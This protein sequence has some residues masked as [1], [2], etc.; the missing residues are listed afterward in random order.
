VLTETGG[1][2]LA[3]DGEIRIYEQSP[4]LPRAFFIARAEVLDRD[5][6]IARMCSADFDPRASVL[7]N[8]AETPEDADS[9]A[10]AG[11][12]PASIT[13]ARRNSV[14]VAVQAPAEGW[15]ILGD[16]Y[17]PGWTATVNGVQ[18]R[19]YSAYLAL[20]AVPVPAGK[21]SVQFTFAPSSFAWSWPVTAISLLTLAAGTA[22]SMR[23]HVRL[24]Q[25]SGKSAN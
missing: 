1:L 10:D 11:I 14:E 4:R 23:T 3:Y 21:S 6:I 19:V 16:A 15:L 13:S 22:M 7:L 9:S 5:T 8:S 25:P 12:V 20:R 17:Y 2:A 18:S 24:H